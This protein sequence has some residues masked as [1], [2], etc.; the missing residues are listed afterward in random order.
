MYVHSKTYLSPSLFKFFR[1][2]LSPLSRRG[3]GKN[4]RCD[5]MMSATQHLLI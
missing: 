3:D 4:G 1:S 2:K 5:H